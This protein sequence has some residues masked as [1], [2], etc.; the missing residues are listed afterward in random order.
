M[1]VYGVLGNNDPPDL[2]ISAIKNADITYIGNKGLW[3]KN[4]GAKIRVGGVGDYIRDSQDQSTAIGDAD[5]NDFVILVSHNPDYFPEVDKSRVDLMLSG[6]T[7]GGQ[8]NLLGLWAPITH[9]KYWQ[10]YLTGV[11]KLD[12]TT[13]V[14]SNGIGTIIAP[15][16]IFAPPEIIV[17][18]LKK[19]N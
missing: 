11:K 14:I 1:G 6:H 3:V 19:K 7:H 16:R 15:L 13:L 8:I 17:I 18:K 4:N 9:S 2:S 10:Q 5:K 12:N